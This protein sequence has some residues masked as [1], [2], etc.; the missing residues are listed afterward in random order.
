MSTWRNSTHSNPSGNCVEV[1]NLGRQGP[2]TSTP[3]MWPNGEPDLLRARYDQEAT[4][5]M[6][7]DKPMTTEEW[8]VR[9][10]AKAPK[11]TPEQW[12]ARRR[13]T[14]RIIAQSKRSQST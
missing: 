13:A 4:K 5:P 14:R 1:Q 6:T 7:T 2:A 10:L 8:L 12:Q 9:E 11:L 3:G